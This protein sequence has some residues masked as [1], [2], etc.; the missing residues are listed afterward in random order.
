M[1]LHQKMQRGVSPSY[2]FL[3]DRFCFPCPSSF[4]SRNGF[5]SPAKSCLWGSCASAS[6]R[7][8]SRRF[9]VNKTQGLQYTVTYDGLYHQPWS[10]QAEKSASLPVLLLCILVVCFGLNAMRP[11]ALH[12]SLTIPNVQVYYRTLPGDDQT[13]G[14]TLALKVC[15]TWKIGWICFL[16]FPF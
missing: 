8:H 6:P 11:T 3:Y 13:E 4:L 15:P 1:N 14:Q 9:V 16:L 7:F 12:L 2:L 10:K 5:F